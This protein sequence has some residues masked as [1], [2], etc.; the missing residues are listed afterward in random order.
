MISESTQA[1]ARTETTDRDTAYREDFLKLLVRLGLE[2][3]QAIALVEAGIGRPF[4]ACSPGQLVP[5]LQELL[6][7]LHARRSPVSVRQP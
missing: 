2:P 6:G 5:L 3:A 1:C 7:L 4:E